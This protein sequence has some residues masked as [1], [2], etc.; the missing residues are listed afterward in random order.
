MIDKEKYTCNNCSKLLDIEYVEQNGVEDVLCPYC[1]CTT[2]PHKEVLTKIP[3]DKSYI[4]ENMIE[5]IKT[6]N[7]YGLKTRF[8][9]EDLNSYGEEK[10]PSL[11][12]SIENID[13]VTIR[14]CEGESR[15]AFEW[16]I[17]SY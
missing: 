12:L 16:S 11:V 8:C 5:L 6:L 1:E 4:D 13:S 10:H 3:E 17:D 9:C 14:N 2:N 7:K 15:L